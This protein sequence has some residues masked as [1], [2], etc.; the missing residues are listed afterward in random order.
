MTART[1]DDGDPEP[2]DHPAIVDSDGVTWLY[3]PDQDG[4]GGYEWVQR[5]FTHYDGYVTGGS[6]GYDWSDI[7][8][9]Y[10]PVREATDEEASIVTVRDKRTAGGKA[11]TQSVHLL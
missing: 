11:T 4:C 7:L 5:L 2:R 9:E 10:G 6:L 3:L 8:E 1:W